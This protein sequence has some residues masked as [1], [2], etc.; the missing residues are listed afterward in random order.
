MGGN[1]GEGGNT[2]A[3]PSKA[4]MIIWAQ[5]IRACSGLSKYSS[6]VK[7]LLKG[8]VKTERSA[9]TIAMRGDSALIVTTGVTKP[10][11][12][13]PILRTSVSYS[14][15]QVGQLVFWLFWLTEGEGTQMNWRVAFENSFKYDSAIEAFHPQN[16]RKAFDAQV[17]N[18]REGRSSPHM[19]D[20]ERR[21]VPNSL[22]WQLAPP[23]L[24]T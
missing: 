4:P 16:A 17:K 2:I 11:A 23:R 12:T 8:S 13:A 15:W 1:V 5:L 9:V 7:R 21:R 19:R 14:C 22:F 6:V 18:D 3:V 10:A 24:C 20:W